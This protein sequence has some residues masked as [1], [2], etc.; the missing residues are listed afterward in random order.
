MASHT[1]DESL[2]AEIESQLKAD[3]DWASTAE[4]GKALLMGKE[5]PS[6]PIASSNLKEYLTLRGYG[7]ALKDSSAERVLSSVMTFPLTLAYGY[8]LLNVYSRPKVNAVVIGARAE[9]TLPAI[10]WKE[11]LFAS[12]NIAELTVKMIGPAVRPKGADD[13][14]KVLEWG[15]YSFDDCGQLVTPKVEL[16]IPPDGACY[17]HE[18]DNIMDLLQWADVFVL[19]NPGLG[20]SVHKEQWDPTMRMLLETRKPILCT[21]HGEDDAIADLKYI[22]A[23]AAQEDHQDIGEPL[24]FLIPPHVNP[25]RTLKRTVHKQENNNGKPIVVTT[26]HYIYAFVAK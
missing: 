5:E 3:K 17:F 9:A 16:S 12:D 23:I 4:A 7:D 10:W 13:A 18:M 21:S 8:K 2:I 1:V 14:V 26:N 15:S 24:E 6:A 22:D 25:F 11:F 20:S 19:Y